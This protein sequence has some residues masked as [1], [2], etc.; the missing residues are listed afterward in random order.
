MKSLTKSQLIDE[1]SA[2]RVSYQALE[3]ERDALRARLDAGITAYRAL[4]AKLKATAHRPITAERIA[5]HD[6]YRA[7]LEAA[8]LEARTTGRS[9]VLAR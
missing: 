1:L 7:K 5:L 9:V 3:A 8:R 6:S 2:L 4:S